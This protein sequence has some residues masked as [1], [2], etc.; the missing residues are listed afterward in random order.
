[1][2]LSKAIA[3]LEAIKG[4]FGD[5]EITGGY[6]SDDTPLR[7]ISVTDS[8]GMEVWPNDPNGVAGQN[9]IDGVFLCS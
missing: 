6:L 5:I 2:K 3:T 4:K 8:E 9:Q 7:E 1:M